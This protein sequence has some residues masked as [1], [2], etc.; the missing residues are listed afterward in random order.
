VPLAPYPT[1]SVMIIRTFGALAGADIN[2]KSALIVLYWYQPPA[3]GCG[4]IGRTERSNSPDTV[5]VSTVCASQFRF[6]TA[7]TQ[8]YN[9]RYK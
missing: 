6:L 5:L 7:T 2:R 9:Q 8:N 4:K 1:S 3:N